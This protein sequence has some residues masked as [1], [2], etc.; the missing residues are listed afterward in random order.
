MKNI[1]LSI[2]ILAVTF[3]LFSCTT[4]KKVIKPD[5]DVPII[6]LSKSSCFGKCKVYN[7]NIFENKTMTY[8]GI[9]NVENIGDFHS[10]IDKEQYKTL[11]EYFRTN[12]FKTFETTYLSGARDLQA[13]EIEYNRQEVKFHKRKAPQLLITILNKLDEIIDEADWT[14]KN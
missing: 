1:I 5:P 13:I 8:K 9:K 7:F 4:K 12:N 6:R 11:I 10:T 14:S 2:A 3:I